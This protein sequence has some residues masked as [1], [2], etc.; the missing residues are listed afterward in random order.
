MLGLAFIK[1]FTGLFEIILPLFGVAKNWPS[2]LGFFVSPVTMVVGYAKLLDYGLPV[3][4]TLSC[5]V[6][7]VGLIGAL[8]TYRAAEKITNWVPAWGGK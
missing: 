5:L 6:F 8:W 2:D 4:E 7:S 1:G 3:T